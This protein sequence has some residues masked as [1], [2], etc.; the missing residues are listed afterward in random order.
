MCQQKKNIGHLLSTVIRLPQNHTTTGMLLPRCYKAVAK[1]PISHVQDVFGFQENQ[2]LGKTIHCCIALW[3]TYVQILD[4]FHNVSG[5]SYTCQSV[6]QVQFEGGTQHVGGWE[7]RLFSRLLAPTI[8][9]KWPH[10]R[11]SAASLSSTWENLH[12]L[13]FP[14]RAWLSM[15]EKCRR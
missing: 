9:S 15:L 6:L 1:D 10:I 13:L 11:H 2:I 3:A 14:R 4:F 5:P 12:H 8:M 7:W